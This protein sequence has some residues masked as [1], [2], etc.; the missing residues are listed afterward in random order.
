LRKIL[1]NKTAM[2]SS[3]QNVVVL[4]TEHC[5]LNHSPWLEFQLGSTVRFIQN[6]NNSVEAGFWFVV[7][8]KKVR[9]ILGSKP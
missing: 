7:D 1:E 8:I 9:L 5:R 6:I 2:T 4:A 3:I